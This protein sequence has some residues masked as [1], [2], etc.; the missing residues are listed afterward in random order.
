MNY[1]MT[2]SAPQLPL[3]S[4]PHHYTPKI[5]IILRSKYMQMFLLGVYLARSGIAGPSVYLQA[6][7]DNDNLLFQF[8]KRLYQ[9]QQQQCL[10]VPIAPYPHQDFLLAIFLILTILN[11]VWWYLIV[12]YFVFFC[13]LI[14]LNI[15]SQIY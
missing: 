1:H 4:L 14:R 6:L 15:F 12:F 7:V 13:Q 3:V 9:L 11:N 2:F 8:P 5:T 10:R